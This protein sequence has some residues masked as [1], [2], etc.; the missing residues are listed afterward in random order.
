VEHSCEEKISN[1]FLLSKIPLAT[2]ARIDAC[3]VNGK[4]DFDLE[5]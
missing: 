1:N 4:S 3:V 2:P 5:I